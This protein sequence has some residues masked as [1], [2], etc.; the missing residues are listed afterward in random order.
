M[1]VRDKVRPSS[2]SVSRSLL[3]PP[4]ADRAYSHP[5]ELGL[6][7]G[8]LLSFLL[9]LLCG[10]TGPFRLLAHLESPDPQLFELALALPPLLL[11]FVV[12]RLFLLRLLLDFLLL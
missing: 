8:F 12:R 6:C 5:P 9:G 7:L 3:N 1:F 10:S 11:V 4:V 2:A